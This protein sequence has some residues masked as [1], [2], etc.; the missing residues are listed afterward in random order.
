MS[1]NNYYTILSHTFLLAARSAEDSFSVTKYFFNL[2]TQV[3]LHFLV[4]QTLF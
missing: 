4:D 2:L 3:C 1:Q